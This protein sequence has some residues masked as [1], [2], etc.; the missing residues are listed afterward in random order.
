MALAMLALR[1]VIAAL[2]N[3]DRWAVPTVANLAEGLAT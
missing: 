3:A 2:V 1:T